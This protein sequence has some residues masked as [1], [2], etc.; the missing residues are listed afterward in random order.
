MHLEV[1]E[2]LRCPAAH[3]PTWLVARVDAMDG[4][5]IRQG[6]LGCPACGA[7]YPVQDGVARIG[8]PA[9]AGPMPD[10]PDRAVR[11]A[12]LLDLTTPHGIVLL[13][14]GWAAVADAVAALGEGLH[15]LALDAPAGEATGHEPQVSSLEAG[16]V[17]PLGDGVTR[18]IALDAA[19]ATPAALVRAV[20][21]LRAGGRLIAPADCP[22]P[23]GATE[24]ARD[25]HWW[26]AQRHVAPAVVPLGRAAPR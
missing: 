1:V 6:T 14:G 4:R 9:A 11:V 12:A 26:V 13:A 16:A 10:D 7:E 2:T 15:V 20:A 3:P 22:V 17:P 5:H 21:A 18:G 23:A 25:A 8:P 19:H 24:L